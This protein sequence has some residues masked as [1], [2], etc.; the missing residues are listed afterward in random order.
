MVLSAFK[1]KRNTCKKATPAIDTQH[2]SQMKHSKLANFMNKLSDPRPLRHVLKRPSM[3]HL[4]SY[5]CS[6]TDKDKT[7]ERRRYQQQTKEK[8]QPQVFQNEQP[9]SVNKKVPSIL[10]R[11]P[12]L[13]CL[14]DGFSSRY[15][16]NP[17]FIG[18]DPNRH[19]TGTD[20][21]SICYDTKK[22]MMD[23]DKRSAY[24][25]LFSLSTTNTGSTTFT[26]PQIWDSAFWFDHPPL[27]R[28][29]SAPPERHPDV[30][31][32]LH[33]LRRINTIST[34]PLVLKRGR[35]EVS[36][37]TAAAAAAAPAAAAE[38]DEDD[39]DLFG[40]D[41]DEVDEEAEKVKAARIAE[42]NAKKANKPKP[43]AK[44]TVTLEVK[45][46]DD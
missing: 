28:K 19:K 35:F 27:T 13:P 38:E 16:S 32:I 24:S 21:S 1:S 33:E 10:V 40:S 41:D 29:V 46:W 43:T 18:G 9:L 12:S 17:S 22:M 5:F 11:R 15:L 25:T 31:A 7:Y 20:D 8:Q 45:P 44:T 34:H 37:E 36:I 6:D 26:Q 3:A 4:T 14:D 23:Q 42:Y 39:I 30:P 2:E